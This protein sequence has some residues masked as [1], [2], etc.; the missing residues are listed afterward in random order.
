MR[1]R[2]GSLPR[3]RW[4]SIER[5]SPPAPRPATAAWRARRSSTSAAIASWLARVSGAFGSSRL[6]RTGMATR[7]ASREPVG[8]PYRRA[9]MRPSRPL[10]SAVAALALL[11][12]S[13]A[14]CGVEA[15]IP[16]A[17]PLV[18]VE[19]RGGECSAAPCGD[20]GLPRAR[21]ARPPGGQAA[22][23]PRRPCRRT[24]SPP[25]TRRSGSRTSRPCAATR[26]PGSA[27]PRSTA[28]R[29]STRSRR[30]PGPSGSRR[31]RSTSTRGCRCSSRSRRRSARG[32]RC[33]VT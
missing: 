31:A 23:R 29:S 4:R 21:R 18:T 19:L 27:R 24:S 20:D 10:V 13:V 3:S 33:P 17:G 8:V 7:I 1:S 32:C 2:T 9:A 30:R 5:S 22:E 25:S 16:T 14:A 28:R 11:A 15:V 6:R 26:S 12:V